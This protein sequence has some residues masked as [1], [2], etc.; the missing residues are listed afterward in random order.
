V[1]GA[2][3][4]LFD[5]DDELDRLFSAI[6]CEGRNNKSIDLRSLGELLHTLGCEVSANMLPAVFGVPAHTNAIDRAQ[7]IAT[8]RSEK[9]PGGDALRCDLVDAWR[10]YAA[11]AN[12][13]TYPVSLLVSRDAFLVLF[14]E[15]SDSAAEEKTKSDTD[16]SKSSGNGGG[17]DNNNVALMALRQSF[18]DL[19][20][21]SK[22][23]VFARAKPAHKKKMVTEM[24]WRQPAS[25]MLAIGDGAND[26]DMIM[27]AH[28]GVGIA[29]VEGTAA[30]NSADYAVG[31]F[32]MLHTLLFG[33]YLCN[34]R[35]V[36]LAACKVH[37]VSLSARVHNS[38]IIILQP[39]V[40]FLCIAR[41]LK[42]PAHLALALTS[43]H[44]SHT[45][46]ISQL[47]CSARLLEL[48]AHLAHGAVSLL[49][50][51]A[52]VDDAVLFRNL[53]GIQ[54]ADVLQRPGI[55]AL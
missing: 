10:R 49:Q 29:G 21:V 33:I 55:S 27:A 20:A 36:S 52:D 45:L 13:D 22:S 18:F 35:V 32:R 38:L 12:S 5:D 26:T 17:G 48:P 16:V 53:L 43:A 40:T 15:K 6:A 19:A 54:R 31:T 7:F 39:S 24:M 51:S 25:R 44:N 3:H 37:F 46:I 4:R 41:L 28:I 30:V 1:T 50:G 9:V 47:F 8:V 42:V 14:P 23:V 34:V 11:I 2:W